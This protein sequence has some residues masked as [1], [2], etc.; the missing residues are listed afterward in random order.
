LKLYNLYQQVILEEVN[1]HSHLLNENVSV[2]EIQSVIAGDEKGK[3][4]HVS[5]D[6]F[7]KK[8]GNSKRWVQIY[9]YV[10]TKSGADAVSAYQISSSSGAQAGWKIFKLERMNNFKVSK[11]PFYNAISDVSNITYMD[12]DKNGNDVERNRFNP[13]GNNTPTLNGYISKVEFGYKYGGD[14]K[15]K[16]SNV[17]PVI[18]NPETIRPEKDIEPTMAKPK[19]IRPEKDIEPTMAKPK[20]IRPMKRIKPKTMSKP[21]T[22]RPEK[23]IEP[24]MAKP[25]TIRPIKQQTKEPNSDEI[26]GL[27]NDELNL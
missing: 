13:T 1:K 2:D 20:T 21:E 27:N 15:P 19:T 3:H 10:K 14:Y 23:D 12:T 6:Y 26:E 17:K 25:K 5:F 7:N 16:L 11:V 24:K 9:D 8:G 22:I 18:P 4:F